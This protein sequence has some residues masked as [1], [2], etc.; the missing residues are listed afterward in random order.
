MSVSPGLALAQSLAQIAYDK[1]ADDVVI[2]DVSGRHSMIDYFVLA[3]ANPKLAQVIGEEALQ[4]AKRQ[5]ETFRQLEA[6]A[7]WVCAD[8]WDVVLHVFTPEARTYYDLD[9]L[10]AD[11]PRVAWVPQEIPA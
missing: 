2:L 3:T 10:W 5:G 9:H 1:K 4:L 6:A 11:A 7:D 8:F